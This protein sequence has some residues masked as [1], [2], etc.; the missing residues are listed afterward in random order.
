MYDIYAYLE[1][2]REYCTMCVN[3]VGLL[4]Y[5]TNSVMHPH[6]API[7]ATPWPFR[8]RWECII[9]MYCWHVVVFFTYPNPMTTIIVLDNLQVLQFDDCFLSSC[10]RFCYSLADCQV[11]HQLDLQQTLFLLIFP[12][13][14]HPDFIP[15]F[16]LSVKLFLCIMC[17]LALWPFLVAFFSTGT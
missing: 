6:V 4:M 11:D 8:P 13:P 17:L 1:L 14:F 16:N 3:G 2:V 12:L 5:W 9:K 7:R 10:S 15:F